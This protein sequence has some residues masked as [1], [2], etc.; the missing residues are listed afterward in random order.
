MLM[1]GVLGQP[2]WWLRVA[3]EETAHGTAQPER[4]RLSS[5]ISAQGCMSRAIL[6]DGHNDSAVE[7]TCAG[8]VYV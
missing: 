1:V 3:A 5:P 2:F 4:A 6:V 8:V 7:H